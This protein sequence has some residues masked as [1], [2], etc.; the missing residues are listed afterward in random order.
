MRI[1]LQIDSASLVLR[2]QGGQRRL[3]YATVNAINNTAKRIQAAERRRVEDE[4]TIRKKQFILRQAA[5]I[6]PFA[7]VKQGRPY[8]EIGVGDKPR[9]L[10]SAFERGAERKPSTQGARRVA[11][12]VVG[13]PARP[14]FS[15]PV[16][17]ELRVKRLRFDRTKTGKRRVGVTQTKTYL[18]PRVGIFQRTGP[19][20]S[21]L[22]YFFSRGKKLKPR[23]KFVATAKKESDRWF[24]E[25]MEKEVVKAIAWSRG[26]GL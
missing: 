15:Q 17:P 20:S 14:R 25:E 19:D 21:R 2:L 23:L 1:D 10:L 16:P 13:G 9:L 6:K 11:E 22:V 8:A 26:R 12:P 4:F 24:R 18:V 5:V 7:N 3:A